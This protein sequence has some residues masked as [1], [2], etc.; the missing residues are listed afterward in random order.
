MKLEPP[1]STPLLPTSV[2]LIGL[3]ERGSVQPLAVTLE[4]SVGQVGPEG[5]GPKLIPSPRRTT[6]HKHTVDCCWSCRDAVQRTTGEH[7]DITPP[8]SAEEQGQFKGPRTCCG[9][10]HWWLLACTSIKKILCRNAS[11]HTQRGR[12][13]S[14]RGPWTSPFH[15]GRGCAHY[16]TIG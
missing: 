12:H 15:G 11:G 3:V 8:A 10:Y 4:N 2:R 9:R 7:R 1:A 6:V 14:P 5:A 16:A 13:S